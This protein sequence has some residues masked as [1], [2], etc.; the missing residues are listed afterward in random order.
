MI[1]RGR[2][3]S[4]HTHS[5]Q[6]LP[7]RSISLL[8]CMPVMTRYALVEES[9]ML[10]WITTKAVLKVFSQKQT[11]LWKTACG[12][13]NRCKQQSSHFLGIKYSRGIWSSSSLKAGVNPRAPCCSQQLAVWET[14]ITWT[15]YRTQ[16]LKAPWTNGQRQGWINKR[17]PPVSRCGASLYCS[18]QA[19]LN[20]RL[21]LQIC[22]AYHLASFWQVLAHK[23]NILIRNTVSKWT[24]AHDEAEGGKLKL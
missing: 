8:L 1:R 14:V 2:W 24:D 23:T 12:D 13:S 5:N 22:R 7:A 17:S 19:E 3:G 18:M 11:S 9:V 15:W 16:H 21:K 10:C 4:A 6:L 20:K